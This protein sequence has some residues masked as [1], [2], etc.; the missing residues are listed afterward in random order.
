MVTYAF[1]MPLLAARCTCSKPVRVWCDMDTDRGGWTVFLR[2]QRQETEQLDF[3]RT[4]SDYKDGF[5]DPEKEHW[6]GGFVRMAGWLWQSDWMVVAEW[7]GGRWGKL[8]AALHPLD[9][10]VEVLPIREFLFADMQI[11]RDQLFF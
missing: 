7:L 10:I 8:N 9:G 3:N 6:L 2:R 4:W 1:A 11:I 5:G